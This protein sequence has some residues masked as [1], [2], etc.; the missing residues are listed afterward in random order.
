V[1]VTLDGGNTARLWSGATCRCTVAGPDRG[2]L[3]AAVA[4]DGER[5]VLT[6]LTDQVLWS[7]DGDRLADLTVAEDR[8]E[9]RVGRAGFHPDGRIVTASERG[10]VSLWS[11]DG[12]HL[13]TFLADFGRASDALLAIA[14]DPQGARIAAGVRDRTILWTWDGEAAGELPV[15]GYKVQSVAWS[16]GGTRVATI[17]GSG[18][19]YVAELWDRRGERVATLD[20][21]RT[22]GPVA[23]DPRERYV[24]LVGAASDVRIFDLDGTRIGLLAAAPGTT[25]DTYAVAPGG[26]LVA[27]AFSDGVARVWSLAERRR[28]MTLPVGDAWSLAFTADS[29][30]LLL[31]RSSGAIEQHA[32]AVA[33]LYDAAR[34]RVDGGL[35]RDQ[36]DRFGI[37]ESALPLS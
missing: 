11:R 4:P 18:S 17:A 8:R 6:S 7:A 27:A 26:E 36:L 20:A 35:T 1:F 24:V 23:F 32:L 33:D 29:R 28:T 30:R 25:L 31:G 34:E 37:A 9:R 10:R 15:P 5:F 21:P 2:T 16:P 22:A 14:A 12:E 3:S 19:A 13:R